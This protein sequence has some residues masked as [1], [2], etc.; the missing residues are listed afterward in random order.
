MFCK[1]LIDGRLHPL[2]NLIQ[3]R[4]EREL[5]TR[6]LKSNTMLD[7]TES[8]LFESLLIFETGNGI[9][10]LHNGYNCRSILYDSNSKILRCF[11]EGSK[12]LILE[13]RDVIVAKL[14]LLLQLTSDSS[15]LNNFYRGRF[16]INNT[17]YE[18]SA[19]GRRCFYLEFEAGDALELYAYKVFL[20]EEL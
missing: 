3:E 2:F 7:L 6:I 4:V 16:E 9:I 18:S 17:L 20:I 15:T 14:N 19:D 11:F 12:N 13:F 8:P 10:D 1:T 5:P